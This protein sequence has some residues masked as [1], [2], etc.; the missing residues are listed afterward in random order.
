MNSK[1]DSIQDRLNALADGQLSSKQREELLLILESDSE[2][3]GEMCDIYRVKDLVKT[4]YP[5]DEY[6]HKSLPHAGLKYRTFAK[7]ASFLMAFLVTLSAGYVL[8]DSGVIGGNGIAID[9]TKIQDDKVILFISSSDPKKFEKALQKA[10]ELA[11]KFHNTEGKVY[12]VA[13]AAGIDLLRTSTSP[14]TAQIK[15][16]KGLYPALD[17][18]ACNNTLY[19]YK[20]MGKPVELIESAKLAPSAVEFVV[21][22]L[23]EGWRYIAI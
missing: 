19:Q 3:R 15:Q 13:S 2:L 23:Q 20:K 1:N 6:A 16:L 14:Y 5:L 18:V 8:R 12:L 11:S 21:K 17:F 22:H 10:E 4:A 9:G 7:V